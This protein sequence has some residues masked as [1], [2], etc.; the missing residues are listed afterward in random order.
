MIDSETG[1]KMRSA[2]CKPL[3]KARLMSPMN[4]SALYLNTIRW[5]K[6]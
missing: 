2:T 4:H 1:K 6:I 3:E 5:L